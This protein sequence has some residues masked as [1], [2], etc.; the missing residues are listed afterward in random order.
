MWK[1]LGPQEVTGNQPSEDVDAKLA[2]LLGSQALAT[3]KQKEYTEDEKKIREAILA[4]Y[5]QMTDDEGDEEEIE[6]STSEVKDNRLERNTNALVVQQ[7]EKEKRELAKIES[8]KK[9]EKD[10]EDRLVFS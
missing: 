1:T 2:R 9:K 7:A 6:C 8:Q 4:Q 10:R 5:S 3:T